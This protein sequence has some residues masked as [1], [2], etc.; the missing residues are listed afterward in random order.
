MSTLGFPASPYTG[1]VVL[2]GTTTYR[3]TGSAWV[4]Y[5]SITQST[6]TVNISNTTTSISTNTGALVVSGG[7]G[8]AGS[9]NIGG[10]STIAGY[11]ILTTATA[12]LQEVTN[13]GATTTNIVHFA[14][15]TE[16]TSSTTGAVVITG[17]L[18][19]GGM[20]YAENLQIQNAIINSSVVPVTNTSNIVIDSYSADVFRSAKYLIQIDDSDNGHFEVVELLVLVTNT[21]TVHATDYGLLTNNGELGEFQTLVTGSNPS[22]MNLYFQAYS[23][24]DKTVTVFRTA[25]TR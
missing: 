11:E 3:Y 25:V 20:L 17:G 10:T 21:G 7:V 12:S 13:I 15:T 16:S 2:I 4:K 5:N 23:P 22:I 18:G 1:Q 19:V 24:S 6:T 9:V 14:N 8:I